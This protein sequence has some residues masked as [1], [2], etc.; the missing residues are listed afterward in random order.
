MKLEQ[1]TSGQ[2]TWSRPAPA[3]GAR[4]ETL[5]PAMSYAMIVRSPRARARGAD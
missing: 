4:I 1:A 3:R 2:L 5:R